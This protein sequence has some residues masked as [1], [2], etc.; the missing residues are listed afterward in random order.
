MISSI[1]YITHNE[2]DKSKWDNCI[3]TASNGIVFAYSWY[4]DA[5]CDNWD[6]LVLNEYEAVFPITKKSKFG[7]NYFFNPIFALQ[8]GV[9]SN[10]KITTGLVNQFLEAIPKKLKL[11]DI[12]LNFGNSVENQLFEVSNKKCQFIDLSSSYEEIS[13]KYS[14][15]LKRNLSKARKENCEIVLSLETENVIKLFK[16]NRGETLKEMKDEQY[17]RLDSLLTQL[18]QRKLGKIYECLFENELVA[19]ACFSITNNRIIYIKGGSTPTGREVGAMHLIMDEVIHLN[20]SSNMIFDFGGSSI[21]QVARFNHSFG[22]TDYEYQ[23]LYRN[24]LPFIVKL[25]KK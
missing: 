16:E 1:R 7:L 23:R 13:K 5:V 19:S 12:Q 3:E 20:S 11:V 17:K 21:E 6:A 2:L 14:T 25:L 10:Q 22:S 18:K 4:L 8:L 9:F 24:N 15:N